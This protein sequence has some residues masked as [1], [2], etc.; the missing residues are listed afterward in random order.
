MFTCP[1][2]ILDRYEVKINCC[3]C[4]NR[5]TTKLSELCSS[6]LYFRLFLNRCG[7]LIRKCKRKCCARSGWSRLMFTFLFF[8][9][10]PRAHSRSLLSKVFFFCLLLVGF[11]LRRKSSSRFIIR[12][13]IFLIFSFS[14]RGVNK[15]NNTRD[16]CLYFIPR[17]TTRRK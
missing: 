4:C 10:Y 1:R 17:K 15:R 14:A 3:C 12:I 5:R 6:I 7:A 9:P 16:G 13:D 2:H 11:L 8:F